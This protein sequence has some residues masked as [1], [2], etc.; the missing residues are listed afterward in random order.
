V[1]ANIGLVLVKMAGRR[2]AI[3]CTAIV[4][5]IPRVNLSPLP[6][7]PSGV[8]GV[9]NLRGRVVPVV[10][11]RARL[12]QVSTPPEAYQHLVIV[13]ARDRQVGLAVDEVEDVVNVL[14]TEIEH[15]GELAGARTH[16][17]V[18]VDDD[19]VLVVEPEDVIVAG[20]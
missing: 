7:A 19:L 1:S 15:P 16:G 8:L 5:I 9:I 18:R 17:V 10:D 12:A 20:R 2:C 3:P 14:A 4:E 11:V 13:H 6:D